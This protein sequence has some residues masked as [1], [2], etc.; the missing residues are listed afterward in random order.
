MFTNISSK[1]LKNLRQKIKLG[2]SHWN[3]YKTKYK[4]IND[5]YGFCFSY[6]STWFSKISVF[7]NY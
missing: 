5:Q 4:I 3:N 1:S 7:F 2:Q 6:N